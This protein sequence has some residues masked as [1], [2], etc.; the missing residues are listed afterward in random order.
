M[1]IDTL[2]KDP[3]YQLNILL[4]MVKE[5]PERGYWVRPVFYQQ[6]FSLLYVEHPSPLPDAVVQQ[7]EASKTEAKYAPEF[8]LL[9][10]RDVDKKAL[11]FEA[12]AD[13]FGVNSDNCKQAR[14]HLLASGPS[15]ME[16]YKYTSCLLCYCVPSDKTGLMGKC[17]EALADELNKK[18]LKTG[19]F[20]IHAIKHI[21]DRLDYCWDSAYKGYIPVSENAVTIM[22]NIDA[23]GIKPMPLLLVY[24][25]EDCY[26]DEMRDFYRKVLIEQVRACLLC[27]LHK[28]RFPDPCG[29]D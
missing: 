4:W 19:G 9:I 14:G 18:H 8:D 2:L 20:S 21:D 17:L 12:K 29:V 15:F 25:D 26:N 1:N 5:Q 28:F 3:I 11:Y 24:S 10:G 7:I 16:M 27:I 6:G 22:E 23:G 13:S